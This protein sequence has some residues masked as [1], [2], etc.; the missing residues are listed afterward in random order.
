MLV[1]RNR[2]IADA[3]HRRAPQYQLRRSMLRAF[4]MLPVSR[5]RTG[6][7][8]R[9]LFIRP[10][11]F[12][13]L[14]MTTPAIHAIRKALPNAEIHALVGPWAAPAVEQNDGLDAVITLNF[15]AFGGNR[16]RNPFA[17]YWFAWKVSRQLRKLQYT[18]A[19]IARPDHWWGAMVA[20]MAG[21]PIR[22]GNAHPDVK[23]FLTHAIHL[24]E[25]HSVWQSV[26]LVEFWTGSLEADDLSLVFRFTDDDRSIVGRYLAERGVKADDRIVC[27]HPSAGN[28]AREWT[29]AHWAVVADTLVDQL[30]A[31]V[32]IS[33]S[34]Q[35][36]LAQDIAN[37][38]DY[39]PHILPGDTAFSQL[40]ALFSRAAVVLGPDCGALHLATAVNAPTVMLFGPSDPEEFGPWGDPDSHV[41]LASSIGCR[42]CRIL[43]WGHDRQEYHPCIREIPV[44][45]VLEAAR[46]VA[47]R[48]IP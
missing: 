48:E 6:S 39:Q 46:H 8:P 16:H 22:V 45:D 33:S 9:I 35:N 36:Y 5:C 18:A 21:I 37:R 11:D 32:V 28:W 44:G 19:V 2:V 27:I 12:T 3:I 43:D 17:P 29:G 23:P 40:A 14:L 4:G 15:P 7:T 41:V 47:R 24:N 34:N 25:R 13:D 30:D 10:D 1:R 26:R 38:M 42:P 31:V 20:F